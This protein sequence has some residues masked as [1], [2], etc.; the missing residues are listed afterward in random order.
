MLV[1]P[2][3]LLP[4]AGFFSLASLSVLVLCISA[5]G[6]NPPA[7]PAD[8]GVL[9]L[10]VYA[11]LD[12]QNGQWVVGNYCTM[13]PKSARSQ[14]KRCD[15]AKMNEDEALYFDV[16]TLKPFKSDNFIGCI[17]YSLIDK[18]PKRVKRCQ[19]FES[20]YEASLNPA[21][22]LGSAIYFV[23]TF[24]TTMV[25][26]WDLDEEKFRAAI[27][28]AS[29]ASERQA[30]LVR[31]RDVRAGLIKAEQ[32][33]AAGAP[34]RQL[35]AQQAREQAQRAEAE[36]RV[37]FAEQVRQANDDAERLFQSLSAATKS[38]G[39]TVCSADNR[40]GYV[41]QIA[42]PRLKILLRGRAVAQRDAVYGHGN[43]L[44][45]FRVDKGGLS[46]E[47]T[48]SPDSAAI[49]L[50]VIDPNYLFKPHRTVR[51]APTASSS[52][53]I[54]DEARFWGGCEWRV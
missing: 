1:L 24:G 31:E 54:W 23:T 38:V 51:I 27:E 36:Y 32:E 14:M 45:P 12:R 41:E 52:G 37:K 2:F 47:D 40:I 22:M 25:R 5:C 46:M 35:A 26:R 6:S 16:A 20:I 43:A 39:S 33:Y 18:A 9:N 49:E 29:P 10:Q 19:D 28:T 7:V 42:G 8:A 30:Y 15:T 11:E 13:A 48:I 34:A 44:G 53:T 21:G 50:P 3:R 4:S 17:D